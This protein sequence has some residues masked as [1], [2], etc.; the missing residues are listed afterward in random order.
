MRAFNK[1]G[2]YI[3]TCRGGAVKNS[4]KRAV[5]LQMRGQIEQQCG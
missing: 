1:V 5:V 3:H 4:E 2:R